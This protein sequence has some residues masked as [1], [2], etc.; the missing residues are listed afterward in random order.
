MYL[1]PRLMPY[2]KNNSRWIL[3]RNVKGKENIGEDFCDL[4]AGQYV[5]NRT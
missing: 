3:A 4:G 2:M 1:D 5:F